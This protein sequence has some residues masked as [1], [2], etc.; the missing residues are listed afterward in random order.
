MI[1]QVHHDKFSQK[2]EKG[3]KNVVLLAQLGFR[4]SLILMIYITQLFALTQK[5]G[6]KV[7][8]VFIS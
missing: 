8:A 7:K 1:R 4:L 5:F 3:L 6:K 2:S